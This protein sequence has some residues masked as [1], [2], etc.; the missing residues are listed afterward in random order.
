[1]TT[2]FLSCA[3]NANENQG[4]NVISANGNNQSVNA[5]S[6]GGNSSPFKADTSTSGRAYVAAGGG[7][8]AF[9]PDPSLATADK[10]CLLGFCIATNKK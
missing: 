2:C 7:G 8:G 6:N 10:F 4:A 9:P 1:M 3:V 5:A